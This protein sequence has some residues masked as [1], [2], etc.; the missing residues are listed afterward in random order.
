MVQTNTIVFGWNRPVPGRE[1]MAAELFG[2]AVTYYEKLKTTGKIESW[3]PV[4]LERHGGDMNGFFIIKGTHVQIDTL[5]SNDEFR[6]LV[7]RADH[8]L[9]GIG[10][11]QAFT[12]SQAVTD[13]MQLY[14]KT[15]PP[16]S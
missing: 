3:E 15:I 2:Q 9:E 10:V 13:L 12:G 14:T 5:V 6:E 1:M 7:M 16:K 11:I 8:Q 4:F